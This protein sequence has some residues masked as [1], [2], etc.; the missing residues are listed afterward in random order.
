MLRGPLIATDGKWNCSKYRQRE[1][2]P[3][4]LGFN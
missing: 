1:S 3:L 4:L 2:T